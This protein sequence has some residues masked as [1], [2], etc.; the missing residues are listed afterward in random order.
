MQLTQIARECLNQYSTQLGKSYGTPDVSHMFA[1]QGPQETRLKAALL[2]SVEFLNM[3]TN[4]DVDQIKGQVVS[5][6]GTAI[7]TGRKAGGRLV[8]VKMLAVIV[9][10]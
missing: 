4:A 1:I 10:N 8:L 5:V 7:A 2:E 6:G 3:I 9:T